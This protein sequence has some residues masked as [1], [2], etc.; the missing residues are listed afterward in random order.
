MEPTLFGWKLFRGACCTSIA[1]WALI[2][3]GRVFEQVN[4]ERKLLKQEGRVE[5]WPSHMQPWLPPWS[6]HGTRNE[7]C[8]AGGCDRRL[9]QASEVSDLAQHLMA[10][11]GPMAE[12]FKERPQAEPVQ[13]P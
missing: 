7:Y 2:I 8:H 6:R 3:C 13:R 12:A 11:M 5:R 4:G 1:M 9:G 10:A